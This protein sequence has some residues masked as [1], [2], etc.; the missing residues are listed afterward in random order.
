MPCC[1]VALRM[2]NVLC[3]FAFFPLFKESWQLFIYRMFKCT[4]QLISIIHI[5]LEGHFSFHYIRSNFFFDNFSNFAHQLKQNARASS[6]KV[7]TTTTE[8]DKF[9]S[10]CESEKG[11]LFHP[12]VVLLRLLTHSSTLVPKQ[13]HLWWPFLQPTDESSL[14]RSLKETKHCET[15]QWNVVYTIS[16]RCNYI[17]TG[18][19]H[20]SM[21]KTI[22]ML[23]V[24]CTANVCSTWWFA[25]AHRFEAFICIFASIIGANAN[26]TG[27][28]TTQSVGAIS[29][30]IS[31]SS[32]RWFGSYLE[33]FASLALE[34]ANKRSSQA[35]HNNTRSTERQSKS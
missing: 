1:N 34:H 32:F 21:A 19:V 33:W 18:Q 16:N 30:V 15:K 25:A 9:Q 22:C 10:K 17:S 6:D 4:L 24:T 14:V 8:L 5:N 35:M 3:I 28:H 12:F 27:T 20:V 13:L 26:Y 2:R 11:E 7:I 31:S 23:F 29:R